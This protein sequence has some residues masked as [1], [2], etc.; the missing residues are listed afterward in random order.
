MSST[1]PPPSPKP[2]APLP[3]PHLRQAS[4]RAQWLIWLIPTIALAIGLWLGV[5]SVLNKGPT[6]TISFLSAA[7]LEAGKTKIRYKDVDIGLV[8]AIRLTPDHKKVEI[9]AE[10]RKFDGVDRLLVADTRFWVV[11][12]QVS[13][14]GVSGLNTL[15]SGPYIGLDIGHSEQEQTDFEGL[16]IP[17]I[18]TADLP[19]RQFLL[20]AQTMG[21]LGIG[22]P[23]YYRHV[24]VGQVVAYDLDR[25]GKGVSFTIFV[26]APY[27]RFVSLHS[28][29]W[30]ASGIELSLGVDG[31]KL[32][33][34]S[35]AS[36]LSGGGIA[37]QD[38]QSGNT[39]S[40]QEAPGDTV[41][42]LHNDKQLALKQPDQDGFDYLL[43]FATSVRGLSVGAPVEFRGLPIGEV[44]AID[45]EQ[46]PSAK[47]PEPR[48]AVQ[49]RVY[50][51]RLPTLGKSKPEAASTQAERAAVDPM[52]ARGF[53][54]QLRNG[55]LLT[56]QLFVALDFFEHATPAKVDWQHKPA[57]FPTVQASLDSLQDSLQS[58]AAKLDQLPLAAMADDMRDTLKTLK[59]T[60]QDADALIK[61]FGTELTP[62]A[63]STLEEAQKA[64]RTLDK[65]LGQVDRTLKPDAPLPRQT[66]TTLQDLSDAARSLRALT[67]YL[68]R[69]PEALVRGKPEDKP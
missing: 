2:A 67:D 3:P 53:R 12:P 34:E 42:T 25:D 24:P 27:D 18:V 55:N 33:T 4:R 68:E 22:S 54:A 69:H 23:I 19:G 5:K 43:L 31:V 8:K 10:L 36:V 26:N 63:R 17:P 14:S 11:R 30:H 57:L 20:K 48:I 50:P 58:I 47:N 44:M 46:A 6:I 38:L 13:A 39:A 59:Q 16:E 60:V 1:E 65:A 41:F 40:D 49:I 51:S 52:V 32:N 62:Q 28:R 64:I 7:G 66:S 21:S 56:G 35:L 15:L 29:F 9:S 61:Q 37:F 45:L